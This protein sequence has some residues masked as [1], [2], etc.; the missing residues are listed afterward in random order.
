M[1]FAERANLRQDSL[2]LLEEHSPGFEVADFWDHGTLHDGS[3]FVIFDIAHPA[4]LF[5]SNFFSKSLLLEISDGVII[6][7]SEEMLN[8]RS[9]FDIVLEVGH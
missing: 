4:R 7:I 6:R 9:S 3:T 5:K 2:F 1:A 8:G